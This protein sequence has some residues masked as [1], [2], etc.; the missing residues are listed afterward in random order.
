MASV[1]TRDNRLTHHKR[2]HDLAPHVRRVPEQQHV[3]LLQAQ[4]HM[5][6]P[7]L[8]VPVLEHR[9]PLRAVELSLTRQL[10]HDNAHGCKGS[11]ANSSKSKVSQDSSIALNET[12][13]EGGLG[14]HRRSLY[15][16]WGWRTLLVLHCT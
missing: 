9:V 7:G 14:I 15:N 2:A 8:G 10:L 3:L 6:P 11:D 1:N 13:E 4:L 12:T 16:S 5:V